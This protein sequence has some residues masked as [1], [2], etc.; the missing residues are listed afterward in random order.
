MQSMAFSAECSNTIEMSGLD[1]R[2]FYR[3]EEAFD[4][5]TILTI[6]EAAIACIMSRR[7]HAMAK[8]PELYWQPRPDVLRSSLASTIVAELLDNRPHTGSSATCDEVDPTTL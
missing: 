7:P 3:R 8:S 4:H 2:S 1:E 6:A 5:R